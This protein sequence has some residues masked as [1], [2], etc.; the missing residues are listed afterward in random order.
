MEDELI[1]FYKNKKFCVI[2]KR[3][4]GSIGGGENQR[5]WCKKKIKEV[6][7][8][9]KT[10]KEWFSKNP[11]S[12]YAAYRLNLLHD[13]SVTGNLVK[14]GRRKW[15]YNNILEKALMCDKAGIFAKNYPSA[16]Q[17]AIKLNVY[18]KSSSLMEWRKNLS[19]NERV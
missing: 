11:Q 18:R 2:N 9:F 5:K 14:T 15:N 4:A 7:K 3:P 16:F 10:F 8:N 6:V 13:K 1:N 17:A 12:Y 19:V